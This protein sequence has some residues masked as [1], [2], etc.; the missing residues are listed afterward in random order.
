MQRDHTDSEPV[1]G[2]TAIDMID[3]VYGAV[4]DHDR[5]DE[6]IRLTVGYLPDNIQQSRFAELRALLENHLA[7]AE[8]MLHRLP[9]DTNGAPEDVPHFDLSRAGLI[10]DANDA[11]R[12]L[13][14]TEPGLSVYEF[15]IPTDMVSALRDFLSGQ[16][17]LP[18]VLRLTRLDTTTPYVVSVEPLPGGIGARCRGVD[19]LWSDEAGEALRTLFKLSRSEAEVLGLLLSGLSPIEVAERRGRS[20]ETVRQQIKAM[21]SKTHSGGIQDLIHL[22]RAVTLST[23]R[24]NRRGG[25]AASGDRRGLHRLPDGRVLDYTRQGNP[26]AKDAVFFLHGC[27]CGNRFPAPAVEAL[28][29][30]SL[31]VI[32]PARP[33]HGQSSGKE[34]F[35]TGPDLYARDLLHLADHLGI[36]RFHIVAFDIGTIYALMCARHVD[37]R[38]TGLTC[39]SAQPPI[40]GLADIASMPAQQR[41]FALMPK[42]SVPL[43]RFMAKAGD[44]RLKRIGE[45]GFPDAVFR[46]APADLRACEDPDLLRLFW[47]GHLFHVENGSE[48][49]IDDCRVVASNWYS[50][51]VRPAT[52]IRFLHGEEN[53]TIPPERI[54]GFAEKLGARMTLV[55]GAGHTLPF[56]HWD[57]VFDAVVGD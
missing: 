5:F 2:S 26:N 21:L 40:G 16:S 15:D 45:R 37:H 25:N 53:A 20:I 51:F 54:F 29:T 1:P 41:V 42:L 55:P 30:R 47:H 9:Q 23:R 28:N 12:S 50:T 35:V 3:A 44:K 52:P 22:A 14:G 31:Q 56:T 48:G 39:I 24:S 6:L 17:T 27:L 38:A 4:L 7:R 10:V 36:E 33:N 49:F 34:A 18:P 46:D 19:A 8:T 11:A 43:L 32:A 13:F 57:A